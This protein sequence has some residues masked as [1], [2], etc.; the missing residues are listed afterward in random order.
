MNGTVMVF[1]DLDDFHN[2][3]ESYGEEV[4][5]RLLKMLS[6]RMKEHF[7]RRWVLYRTGGDEF[8]FIL[9]SPFR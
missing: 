1:L 4:G 9:K 2:I 7:S 6:A 8:V 5:N 3:N